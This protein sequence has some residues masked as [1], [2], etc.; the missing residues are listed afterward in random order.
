M[1]LGSKYGIIA[2]TGNNIQ[3]L[4][5]VTYWDAAYK[6][7]YTT[8]SLNTFNLASGSLTPTGSLKNDTGF[9]NDNQ[10][11]WVFD[12]VDDYI[13]CGQITELARATTFTI[14]GWFNQT[15]ID[16]QR[17]MW[18]AFVS[19]INMITAYTWTDG[20][21]Y[22]DFRNGAS[23][24][25]GFD[26]STLVTAGE[27]FHCAC[28]FDGAGATKPD[29]FKIYIDGALASVTSIGT[30]TFPTTSNATQGDFL[31]GDNSNWDK[32]WLGN[33]ANV[34][35]YNKALSVGDILQNYNAQKNRFGL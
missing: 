4:G 13:N 14:S 34:K 26:Y 22:F 8:G 24:Y 7:S 20:H 15:T 2:S 18:G 23:S 29:K 21:M 9:S 11:S 1:G 25:V 32:E 3:T 6:K 35:V 19:T 30:A 17:F 5:L 31:I 28:V 33:I 16:Q 27:W 12:G 10:G